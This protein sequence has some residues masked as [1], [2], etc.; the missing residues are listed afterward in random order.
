MVEEPGPAAEH[1]RLIKR[2]QAQCGAQIKDGEYRPVMPA[3]LPHPRKNDR[4]RQ[5]NED[6]AKTGGENCHILVKDAKSAQKM[7]MWQKYGSKIATPSKTRHSASKKRGCGKKPM[8]ARSML[9][10]D[11]SGTAR[12]RAKGAKR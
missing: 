6:V 8:R 4:A 7:R 3:F 10:E 2:G 9:R 1:L 5:R 11:A 12:A